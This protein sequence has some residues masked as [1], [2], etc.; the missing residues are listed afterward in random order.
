VDFFVGD[1]YF[2]FFV[3]TPLLLIFLAAGYWRHFFLFGGIFA[4]LLVG[5]F[6]HSPTYFDVVVKNNIQQVALRETG[7][8]AISIRNILHD[9]SS[10]HNLCLNPDILYGII[11]ICIVACSVYVIMTNISFL[12]KKTFLLVNFIVISNCL[13]VPLLKNYEQVI[14]IPPTFYL[15]DYLL[16]KKHFIMIYFLF[17]LYFIFTD[18][19]VMFLERLTGMDLQYSVQ[20]S[21]YFI[22]N[23]HVLFALIASW[24]MYLFVIEKESI[25][26]TS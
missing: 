19:T 22:M 5:V 18:R 15:F 20:S 11:V 16:K 3:L 12:R 17:L 14:L 9:L 6:V 24:I 13:I 26:V 1:Y 7:H 2:I 25:N 10:F 21:V 23:Y 8:P 4:T